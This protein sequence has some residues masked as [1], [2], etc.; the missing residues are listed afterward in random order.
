MPKTNGLIESTN[1]DILPGTR[2]QLVEA[3]LPSCFWPWAAQCYCHHENT[4]LDAAGSSPWYRRHGAH[5]S[6]R[7]YPCGCGVY[8]KPSPTK[9][10]LSKSDSTMQYGI[11]LG[12]RIQRWGQKAS[13]SHQRRQKS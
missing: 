5:W 2:A 6:A 9:Y 13:T 10:K 11:F 1:G 3:G 4:R 8:F 7:L 12:Y